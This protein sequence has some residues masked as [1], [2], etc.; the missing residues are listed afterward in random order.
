MATRSSGSVIRKNN[1]ISFLDFKRKITVNVLTNASPKGVSLETNSTRP[2]VAVIFNLL[3]LVGR[4]I[5][6]TVLWLRPGWLRV[7]NRTRSGSC[8]GCGDD[9][10]AG[11]GLTAYD[12][13]RGIPGPLPTSERSLRVEALVRGHT[14]MTTQ[15]ALVIVCW[16]RQQKK[17]V[18][19]M[20]RQSLFYPSPTYRRS[21]RFRRSTC[22]RCHS[23][24]TGCTCTTLS[25]CHTVGSPDT[26][27]RLSG[28]R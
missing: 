18:V 27:E 20:W 16:E 10:V 12:D 4:L 11:R 24:A 2:Q 14:V 1:W 17:S 15:G 9:A 28:T 26:R 6:R 13:S 19:E 23:S 5:H 25:C 7:I 22:N 3:A 8:S 21:F